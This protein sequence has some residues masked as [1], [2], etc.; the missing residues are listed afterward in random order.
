MTIWEYYARRMR[1]A[2]RIA[3]PLGVIFL[4]GSAVFQVLAKVRINS[5][6]LAGAAGLIIVWVMLPILRSTRCPRCGQSLSKVVASAGNG[7][8]PQLDACSHCGV[9][10]DEQMRERS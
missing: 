4:V 2:R 6:Y 9:S 8:L 3:I 1:L 5:W 10:L 7:R